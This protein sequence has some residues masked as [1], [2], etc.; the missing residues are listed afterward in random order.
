MDVDTAS[1][2]DV[3]TDDGDVVASV[4]VDRSTAAVD[5]GYAVGQVG[6]GMCDGGGAAA[7]AK[8]SFFFDA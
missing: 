3:G 5:V 6:I 4:D 1:T 8:P 2:V 7:Q